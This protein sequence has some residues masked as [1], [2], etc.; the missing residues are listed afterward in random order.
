MARSEIFSPEIGAR[1]Q[2]ARDAIGMSVADLAAALNLKPFA[3]REIE[4]GRNIKFWG[5][6]SDFARILGTT[7]NYL[8]GF[9]S[10]GGP[11][12][13]NQL[14]MMGAA[15]QVMLIEDGWERERAEALVD[16]A[17][18]VA[19]EKSEL[20]LDRRLAAAFR[21]RALKKQP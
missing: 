1:V 16:I 14:D 7:P 15:V 17:T 18:E 19:L 6:V 2:A 21:R 3:V 13:A 20:D 9:D 5:Q 12:P 4:A 8:L 10:N 11:P